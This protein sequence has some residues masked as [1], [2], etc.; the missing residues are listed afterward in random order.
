MKKLILKVLV[1]FAFLVFFD[2]GVNV[3]SISLNIVIGLINILADFL[4]LVY[5][6]FGRFFSCPSLYFWKEVWI[7]IEQYHQESIVIHF[8]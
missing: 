4:C 2:V 1:S 6:T 5:L 8:C 3:V 7:V